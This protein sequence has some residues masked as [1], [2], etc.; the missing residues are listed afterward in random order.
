MYLTNVEGICRRFLEEKREG[1][2]KLR[3]DKVKWEGMRQFLLSSGGKQQAALAMEKADVLLKGIVK[4]FFN[5][6][7]VTS[8]LVMDALYCGCRALDIGGT[9]IGEASKGFKAG[10][11]VWLSVVQ[12]K[13]S[14]GNRGK[15]NHRVFLS[16]PPP[17][18]ME[19]TFFRSESIAFLVPTLILAC[20]RLK[21]N[22]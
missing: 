8:T 13:V 9:A 20:Q 5:E 6:K 7:E 22:G 15:S 14:C 18:V 16:L 19:V 21:T 12:N 17:L 2:A 10:R 4:R 3:E 1:L 11:S